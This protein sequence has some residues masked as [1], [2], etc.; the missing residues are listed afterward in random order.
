MWA[1]YF[2]P[3]LETYI[4][5]PLLRMVLRF[6]YYSNRHVWQI[7]DDLKDEPIIGLFWHGELVM[8]IFTTR[9]FVHKGPMNMLNSHHKDGALMV[10]TMKAFGLGTIRGSSRHG[11][12]KA[13]IDA[14]KFVKS[15]GSMV[16]TPDG[17]KGPRHSVSNGSVVL[18]QKADIPIVTMHAVPTKYWRLKTWD[19][20]IIP[21]PFGTITFIIGKPFKV[22][23]LNI[24]DAKLK[25]QEELL[26]N[27][28]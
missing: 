2:K 22:T 5:P 15:G 10:N 16:I 18:A 21:K 19:Q 11:S 7:S 13:L 25:V 17:P 20:L 4:L 1:K 9:G 6:L 23:D 27:S 26:K 12:V 8:Q 14:M 28:L 3:F 24:E